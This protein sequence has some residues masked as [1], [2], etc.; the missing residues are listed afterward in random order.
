MSEFKVN[1]ITN[2]D[3]SYGPQ[4]CG[5][6]TFG[7]SGL[8]LPSGPTDFRGGRGRGIFFGGDPADPGNMTSVEIATLGNGTDFGSLANNLANCKGC[9]SSTRGLIMGGGTPTIQS[10]IQGVIISSSGGVFDFGDLTEA[11]NDT[12]A[13]ANNV[14]GISAGGSNPAKVTGIEFVTIS[15]AGDA[16]SFGNDSFSRQENYAA[17]GSATRGIFA[18]GFDSPVSV[19]NIN[20]FT[21]SS[22][23][24]ASDFG[25]LILQ[26]TYMSGNNCSSPTRGILAGGHPQLTP[27]IQFYNI[28]SKGD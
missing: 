7:S 25:D 11:R 20:Y 24:D 26:S 5:I 8:Q 18:G 1:T 10:G 16:I 22:T 19:S 23:G 4:V 14:R 28:Q 17:F 12:Q 9:A 27:I 6:T 2:R 21:F 13:V 15:S 3:G